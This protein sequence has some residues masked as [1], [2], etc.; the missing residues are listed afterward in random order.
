MRRVAVALAIGLA[1]TAVAVGV[2]LTRSPPTV[3]AMNFAQRQLLGSAAGP[4]AACQAGET[5]PR[6]TSAI[7]LGLEAFTGPRVTLAVYA[8]GRVIA[9]GEHG[10]GWTGN[11]VTFPIAPARTAR[12]GVTICFAFRI[13]DET[14]D[15]RGELTKPSLAAHS[16]G[17]SPL[18]GRVRVE[19]LR[20]GRSWWSLAPSVARRIGL[21]HALSG[22][23]NVVL[24]LVL[25]SALVLCAT[26]LALRELR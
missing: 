22:V 21:G 24:V 19:Y 1:A 15:A 13:Q 11:V 3:I 16:I 2:T 7:R 9:R 25:M 5:L 23:W 12:T 20:Q 18:P 6:G 10:S 26:R 14:L 17:G 4:L 8:G